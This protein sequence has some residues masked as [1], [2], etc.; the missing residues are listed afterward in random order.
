MKKLVNINN[1]K[2][3]N[4]H[5]KIIKSP[6]QERKEFIDIINKKIEYGRNNRVNPFE[7]FTAEEQDEIESW[8][9]NFRGNE[10]DF[11][12]LQKFT[13]I[14]EYAC[15]LRD[16]SIFVKSISIEKP[17]RNSINAFIRILIEKHSLFSDQPCD[18]LAEMFKLANSVSIN[19]NSD[20]DVIQIT[21]SV[22]NI[23]IN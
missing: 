18:T 2:T 7:L 23:W 10:V 3:G 4:D 14:G 19:S 11:N 8:I 6:E 5:D 16:H 20:N 1:K 22:K 12:V 15:Y 17:N 21:F 13:K 9:D